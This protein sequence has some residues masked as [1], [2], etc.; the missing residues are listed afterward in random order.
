M[1]Y[2]KYIA[3]R[4]AAEMEGIS[5]RITLISDINAAFSGNKEHMQKLEKVY[6][7]LTG[8]DRI[9]WQKDVDWEKRLSRFKR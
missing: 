2:V 7:A 1:P 8:L 6:N 4:K 5:N 9:K 3:L